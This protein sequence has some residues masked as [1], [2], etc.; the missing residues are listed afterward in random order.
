[1]KSL[2]IF[3]ALSI[4]PL[5]VFVGA[6]KKS[7]TNN[8]QP[9][10][11]DDLKVP[12]SFNWQTTRKVNLNIG[13]NLP[14]GSIGLL[15]RIFIYDGDPLQKGMLLTTG[16]SGYL[17]PF[18]TPL[19]IP[20]SLKQLYVQIK[21]GSGYEQ[22]VVVA[23]NDIISY[24]FTEEKKLK[25]SYN[26]QSE[27]DC[28]S[29]CDQTVEGNVT[30]N[31][32]DGKTYCV[33]GSF[34]GIVNFSGSGGT[35]KVCG[36]ASPSAVN[37]MNANCNI[38]VTSNGSF[39]AG[40]MVIGQ[41]GTFTAY[42]T[43]HVT[44]GNLNLNANTATLINYSSDFTIQQ[45][46]SSNSS[47]QNY[48][49][50]NFNGGLN[51]NSA[52]GSLTN[53][54]IMNVQG[55]LNNSID[56][57]NYGTIEVFGIFNVNYT[58]RNYCKLILHKDTYINCSFFM[59]NGYLKEYGKLTLG[60]ASFVVIKN[61]SMISTATYVQAVDLLGQGSRNELKVT[62]DASIYNSTPVNGAIEMITTTGTLAYGSYPANFSNGAT[63]TS[64]AN[65]QNNIPTDE[66]NPEGI[67]APPV[68]DSD[69]DGVPNNLDDYPNDASRAYN[70]YYPSKTQFGSIAFE[71]LWPGKGDYDM[72][73]LVV[74]YQYL[75]VTNAQ[76]NVVDIN[77]KFYVRAAG[78]GLQN[79]FGFQL[80][81]VLPGQVASVSGSSLLAG[82]ISVA[83]NGLENN[84]SKAVVI[85]TDNV[86]NL[87]H[88][89]AGSSYFYNTMPNE[90]KGYA[91]TLYIDL[92]L[93][94]PLSA[95]IVGTPPY[96]CFLIKN[97]DRG[98]EVH[99]PDNLPTS[100]ANAALFGTMDDASIPAQGKYYKT[101]T[102]LPW[103]IMTPVKFDY[104]YEKIQIIQGFLH[105]GDWAQSGGNSYA[106]WYKNF[107]GYRDVS[108]IYQ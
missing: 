16:S 31:I 2:R 4:L 62:G 94:N 44:I 46:F 59:D 35:L 107:S 38:I 73:D 9:V 43:A 49:T 95:S 60:G 56:I 23:V 19:T 39:T 82:Y 85:A 81:N 92:H 87:I 32:N 96:N 14:Q 30:V 71:D 98:V 76:N 29:N 15:S 33:S 68:T 70:T 101:S 75:V 11:M 108:K 100:L 8:D 20:T 74:D 65:A 79:G 10:S 69:G 77:P 67:G 41:G 63:L 40:S 42:S 64:I 22:I 28:N 93:L 83:A 27:P 47:F 57:W 99:M 6:C 90:P 61:H 72:N 89:G 103:A 86:N 21:S 13:V 106:D 52:A 102:N 26:A 18:E 50:M 104:T 36:T 1:M 80:D 51:V 54:G 105:F 45:Q 88:R 48:G 91:D 25:N 58:V 12:A 55:N 17:F 37:N 7:Q 66:C 84:Q 53:N 5:V 3:I 78:A 24:T 34:T 97:L